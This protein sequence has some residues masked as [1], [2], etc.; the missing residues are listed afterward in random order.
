MGRLTSSSYMNPIDYIL[1]PAYLPKVF[2]VDFIMQGFQMD[3]SY[4]YLISVIRRSCFATVV[5]A[6][7]SAPYVIIK[8]KQVLY[9][10]ILLS[11]DMNLFFQ[12]RLERQPEIFAPRN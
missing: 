12:T 10:R 9:I 6:L 4:N 8:R 3:G 5:S 11:A 1:K 7:A 2:A